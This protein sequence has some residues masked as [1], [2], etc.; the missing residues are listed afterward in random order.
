MDL[1]SLPIRCVMSYPKSSQR[2][3]S[4]I[5]EIRKGFS[6]ESF[7]LYGIP[8]SIKA[9]LLS[10][11]S[12]LTTA[13]QPSATLYLQASQTVCPGQTIAYNCVGY[14]IKMDL[15]SPPIID[16]D[17]ALTLYKNNSVETCNV[18]SGSAAA[19]VLA[20]TPDSNSSFVRTLLLYITAEQMQA[21]FDVYCRVFTAS[22]AMSVT[23][24]SFTVIKSEDF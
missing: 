16:E 8:G 9:E 3:W 4:K 23:S 20:N 10:I 15:F 14:G 17:R 6:L 21:Y 19:V 13:A 11:Y 5:H 1:C 12:C 22:G 2:K 7:P 18:R 24:A